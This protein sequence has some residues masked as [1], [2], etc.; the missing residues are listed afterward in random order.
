MHQPLTHLC[1]HSW[2]CDSL[3]FLTVPSSGMIFGKNR[4]V[5]CCGTAA[6]APPSVEWHQS[7]DTQQLLFSHSSALQE[8]S[9]HIRL[10]W[11][12]HLEVLSCGE[13]LTFA[14]RQVLHES[15]PTRAL[16]WAG[17]FYTDKSSQTGSHSA[18]TS[19]NIFPKP[20]DNLS[21]FFLHHLVDR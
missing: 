16:W 21:F 9:W 18:D 14:G 7:C 10:G 19:D 11:Q 5:E 3:P 1:S 13:A 6:W 20:L 8:F 17:A 2:W 12:W 4:A 15:I